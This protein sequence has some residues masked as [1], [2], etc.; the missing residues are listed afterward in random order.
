MA[1]GQITGY[2]IM[3]HRL[4]TGAM[5]E[6]YLKGTRQALC[7]LAYYSDFRLSIEA[8]NGY[9][10]SPS[11]STIFRT[12]QSGMTRFFKICIVYL[13]PET[14][15]E[16]IEART[17]SADTIMLR[18]Y[19]P[20]ITN[21]VILSYHLYFKEKKSKKP[22]ALIR[23][24]VPP[25]MT[26]QN[27]GHNVTKLGRNWNFRK[28]SGFLAPH[29]EYELQISALTV[30]GESKRSQPIYATTDFASKFLGENINFKISIEKSNFGKKF[31]CS[32]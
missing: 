20:S 30:K 13:V 22:A 1:H 26:H 3:V 21:G 10:F 29:M 12:D 32:E 19:E 7:S 14:A 27:F 18:W 4:S 15:P 11:V 9:G 31:F 16:W 5:R 25:G 2:R 23:L 24:L 17:L 6:W 8:D 28:T